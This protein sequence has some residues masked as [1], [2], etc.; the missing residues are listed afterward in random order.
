M[1]MC[2]ELYTICKIIQIEHRKYLNENLKFE[3][4]LLKLEATDELEETP[5]TAA[6]SGRVE[7]LCMDF[8]TKGASY[9]Q[10]YISLIFKEK[11]KL[12]G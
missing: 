2:N 11:L 4:K 12:K 7:D 8:R 5:A 3:L 10:N 1:F 6:V 9:K